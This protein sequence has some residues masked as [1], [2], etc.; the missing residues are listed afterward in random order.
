MFWD[1]YLMKLCLKIEIRWGARSL[2]M[3]MPA[4][5]RITLT[6]ARSKS[7][8]LVNVILRR[9]GIGIPS[10]RAPHLISIFKHN[11]NNQITPL[12]VV[13]LPVL[14]VIRMDVH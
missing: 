11:L 5:L 3:P 8:A 9:A 13:K 10:E 4:R 2:G 7:R 6:N 12:Y 1:I 14:D